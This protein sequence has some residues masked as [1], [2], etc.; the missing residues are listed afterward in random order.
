MSPPGIE[1]GDTLSSLPADGQS[2]PP[3]VGTPTA[4]SAS[5]SALASSQLDTEDGT[6]SLRTRNIS[7]DP[8]ST[9]VNFTL[10]QRQ[11]LQEKTHEARRVILALEAAGYRASDQARHN[12]SRTFFG[13]SGKI[14]RCGLD[15]RIL[16]NEAQATFT[17]RR[18]RC[19]SRL[20]PVCG[21]ERA[22]EVRAKLLPRIQRMDTARFLTLTI[23]S[24][25]EPLAV[26][27]K[28]LIASFS[29]LRRQK[30]FK[31]IF[32]WGVYTLE[33][34]W[35][36]RRKQ[37]HPHI[38]AVYDGEWVSVKDVAAAWSKITKGSDQVDIRLAR[39]RSQ[40]A[41]YLSDY[42]SKSADASHVPDEKIEEWA[43]ALHGK[44]TIGTFGDCPP[45]E[46]EDC[47]DETEPEQYDDLGPLTQ[48]LTAST[49]GNTLAGSLAEEL[50]QALRNRPPHDRPDLVA[51]AAARHRD[52]ARR[53]RS[54][55]SGPE[56]ENHPGAA[57]ELRNS[58]PVDRGHH[59][60]EWL[61]KD[62]A[63]KNVGIVDA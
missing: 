36:P 54:W 59:G 50:R 15:P 23:R 18:D 16:W 28:K 52:L 43:T 29:K 8:R 26:Q 32:G 44:R 5:S 13:I 10:Y 30:E 58:T 56:E 27:V 21:K 3:G 41:V 1:R 60:T 4:E 47:D 45:L 53:L 35:N 12:A 61:W 40:V 11:R 39:S 38:H 31:G 55:W 2:S 14:R 25:D 7:S 34:T 24:T 63:S 62:H 17:V 46:D 22:K 42:I 9:Y 51:E 6:P 37:W 49:E 48:L 33:I 19:R 57:D 20:C